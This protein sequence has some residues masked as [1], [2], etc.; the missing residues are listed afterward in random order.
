M[1]HCYLHG[2]SSPQHQCPECL[3]YHTSASASSLIQK[4]PSWP[5]YKNTK[6]SLE[7]HYK[8]IDGI[9]ALYKKRIKALQDENVE[10]NTL[11]DRLKIAEEAIKRICHFR[12]GLG[13]TYADPVVIA[14]HAKKELGL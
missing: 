7:D 9:V 4:S 12:N 2:W 3:N 5:D 10:I 11:R 13:G 6:I 1:F 14:E 8:K